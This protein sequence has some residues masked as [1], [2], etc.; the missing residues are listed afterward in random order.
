MTQE[1][2]APC[3]ADYMT[4]HVHVI[5]P[6]MPLG[7][8]VQFLLQ[9][10][11]SNT[12]VVEIQNQK[13]VLIGFISERDCLEFLSNEAFYGCPS[14]PQTARTIMRMHPVCV[15][16]DTELFTLASIFSSHSYRHLPVVEHD[17]LIGI[18]S[19]RDVLKALDEYYQDAIKSH[20]ERRFRPDLRKIVNLRFLAKSL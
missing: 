4:R 18:I 2:S 14:P 12:P 1:K 3:A 20:D 13:Q 9:H 7:D 5:T 10:E 16:P 11:I 17:E 19:R 6:D 15:S 8:V